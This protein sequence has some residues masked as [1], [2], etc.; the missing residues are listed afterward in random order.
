MRV[1]LVIPPMTQLNTP[2]PSTAYLSG[3][4]KSQ[5]VEVVQRDLSLELALK[6]FSRDGLQIIHKE[7]LKKFKTK[8]KTPLSVRHFLNHADDYLSSIDGVVRLLQG[9]DSSL[10][11]RMV[12]RNFLPEGPSFSV[13]NSLGQLETG[14]PLGWAFGSLGTLD[15]AK[16]FASLMM[17][18]LGLMVR[19]GIDE[20]FE[21]VRFGEKLAASQ[22]SFEG[23]H[24]ALESKTPTLLDAWNEELILETVASNSFDLVGFTAPFPGNAY[25]AFRMARTLKKKIP[26]L[27]LVLGG[28]WV[29]TELRHLTEPRVFDYFDFISLDDGERPLMSLIAYLKGERG[30]DKI[31]RTYVC[32][33]G[34]DNKKTVQ[35]MT[36]THDHDVPHKNL[37]APS[38]EGLDMSRYMSVLEMLNPMHRVWSDGRWNKLTIAHGCY[39][40]KCTF[41]DVSLDYIGRFDPAPVD[42]I[43]DR[44]I[45][46]REQT[47]SSGF[48]FVDEAAP[49]NLLRGL[50]KR[51]L[52]RKV[53]TSWWG[54]I[55]FEKAFTPELC[56]LMAKAGCVAVT[57]GLEVASD[58]L[59]KL[60]QKGV[61]VEQVARVTKAFTD[62]GVMVHA[63]LMYGFPSQTEQETIDS[64]ERV[65][66]LF[67][68]G[69]IQSAFWHRFSATIHS[70][71][72]INP[73]E[74]GIKISKP[75]LKKSQKI[76]AMNDLQFDDVTGVD[77]DQYA[78]GLRKAL[79]NYM[80]GV[81]LEEDVRS[82]YEFKVPKAK[83]AKDFIERALE[84]GS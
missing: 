75:T 1:L 6:I 20:R 2:Y 58:R 42:L 73:A 31:F 81:G 9:R 48:H 37:G 34:K 35:W 16:Y 83:V 55:R 49:P 5:G 68:H 30:I 71:V 26:Q 17:A 65:R 43:V 29:N 77:H 21:M 14:D 18:D 79:Y 84:G 39:W 22:N 63:Y 3:Y 82:W 50:S 52:E 41:C 12:G 76:F 36:N 78:A 62:A 33:Q 45:N 23:L 38:Y 44:M 61:S 69:C 67:L 60:I 40:K 24:E 72:G 8:A 7:L 51:L 46:V 56:D 74:Y 15:R 64:L 10:A 27:P 47:G 53:V 11:L 32:T 28:G 57:G 19:E 80:H 70:P 59:L 4:L 13:L 25:A 54:N 66:Q